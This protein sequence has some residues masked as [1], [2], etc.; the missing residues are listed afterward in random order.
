[1]H[2]LALIWN[3]YFS[4]R[5]GTANVVAPGLTLTPKA[6]EILPVSI[7]EAPS[8]CAPSRAEVPEDLVGTVFFLASPDSDFVTGQSIVVDGGN[9][10]L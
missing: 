6:R 1:V 2:L 10:M 7:Q 5:N 9:T 3:I 8:D 4:P